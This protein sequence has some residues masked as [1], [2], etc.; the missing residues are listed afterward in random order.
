VGDGFVRIG[1]DNIC[2]RRFCVD[3]KRQ[4]LWETVL[5]ERP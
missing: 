4:H 2:G 5:Y 1:R 3:G